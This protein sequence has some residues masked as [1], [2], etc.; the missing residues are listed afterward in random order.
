MGSFK[1]LD[2]CQDETFVYCFQDS[3][4]ALGYSSLLLDRGASLPVFKLFQHMLLKYEQSSHWYFPHLYEQFESQTKNVNC[5][6][7][8]KLSSFGLHNHY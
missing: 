1:T 7:N 2:E 5:L 3:Q 4:F 6:M 8:Q